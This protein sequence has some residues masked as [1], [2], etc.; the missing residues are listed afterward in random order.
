[1]RTRK[2]GR[3]KAF[4]VAM[5]VIFLSVSVSCSDGEKPS[6]YENTEPDHPLDL[7]FVFSG[8]EINS[9][10]LEELF[11]QVIA[12]YNDSNPYQDAVHM[13][14]YPEH[15]ISKF[16]TPPSLEAPP[17]LE[18]MRV[19]IRDYLETE[20]YI[21]LNSYLE[22]D[23]EWSSSFRDGVF[24]FAI[25]DGDI[26]Q[27]P[28]LNAY[29]CVFYNTELFERAGI[30]AD[31]IHSW[32]DFLAACEALKQ[33]GV[34]PIAVS[35][36]NPEEMSSFFSYLVLRLG[37]AEPVRELAFCNEGATF[38][39]E[40]FL[41]SGRIIREM[42]EKGYVQPQLLED[43]RFNARQRFQSGEAAMYCGSTSEI[44]AFYGE[45]SVVAG[46]VGV[47]PFPAVQTGNAVSGQWIGGVQ[48]LS[49]GKRNAYP[50]RT[51]ELIQHLTSEEVQRA[52]MEDYGYIPAVNITGD[53]SKIK[54][55]LLQVDALSN[56]GQSG[57]F[58][59]LEAQFGE[60]LAFKWW[61]AVR[62]I[63]GGWQSP[64]EAFHE[65]QKGYC[66]LKEQ[67]EIGSFETT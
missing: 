66:A 27:I 29:D 67:G 22:Q 23:A 24:D 25:Y 65:A 3:S 12:G 38:E 8:A 6:P 55:E 21:P 35:C 41:R 62:N 46:K 48:A 54:P 17:D 30:H 50:E 44:P 9:E 7:S 51:V 2:A 39:Q 33:A 49:I 56:R 18:C 14:I 59:A 11:Y 63:I 42:V 53:T 40:C 57:T 20:R 19:F 43:A 26:L 45:Q 4:C 13:A 58:P 37:G 16:G 5:A 10:P 1:M 64:E 15:L 28:L 31:K 47:L 52:I 36:Q 60:A 34:I 32:D 61:K